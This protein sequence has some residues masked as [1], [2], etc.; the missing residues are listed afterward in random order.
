MTIEHMPKGTDMFA[1]ATE[2][3]VC[4]VN[5]A[6]VL[7]AGLARVFAGRFPIQ[8]PYKHACSLRQEA[9]RDH[10]EIPPG[11]LTIGRVLTITVNGFDIVCVP[12]KDHWRHNSKLEDVKAGIDALS[13]EADRKGWK[14]IHI[15]ALGC[16]LGKLEWGPVKTAIENAF[17]LH[18]TQAFIYAPRQI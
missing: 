15:P 10:K 2:A 5:C 17:L 9:Q 13:R 11:A 18:S 7:G 1:V 16:G 12:T 6:G 3:I 14:Q 4:P 8:V